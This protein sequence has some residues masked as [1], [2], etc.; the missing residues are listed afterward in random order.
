MA[1]A[2]PGS[3]EEREVIN[4]T[5]SHSSNY[6]HSSESPDEGARQ[7]SLMALARAPSRPL[8]VTHSARSAHASA[9]NS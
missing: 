2:G 3:A 1:W 5:I 4:P 9:W 6:L 8:S 7:V